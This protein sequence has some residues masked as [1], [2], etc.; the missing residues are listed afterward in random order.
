MTIDQSQ[1]IENILK[2][3]NMENVKSISSPCPLI[4]LSKEHCPKTKDEAHEMSEIQYR[5]VIGSL[6]YA[7]VI[8]RPDIINSVRTVSKYMQNPGMEH[9]KSCK[10]ILQ[11]L[12]LRGMLTVIMDPTSIKEDQFLDIYFSTG[13]HQF[14]GHPKPKARLLSQVQRRNIWP[15]LRDYER[16]YT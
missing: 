5:Q 15:Y 16:P 11:Y 8:T 13:T 10:R 6:L 9:W 1:Y 3:F 14:L 4:Q 12:K 2:K 7:A